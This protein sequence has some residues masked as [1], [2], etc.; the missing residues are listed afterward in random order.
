MKKLLADYPVTIETPVAWGEMDAFKHVNNI[1]YFRYFES[2][3]IAYF[4][5]L[6]LMRF[7]EET[8]IGPI[9]ASTQCK[10]KYPL[11]YPD[12]VTVG[13]TV[14]AIEEERFTM[15]YVVVSHTHEL[16]AAS[17]EGIIVSFNYRENKKTKIPDIIR[18]RIF[19]LENS[20][21]SP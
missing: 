3:R 1:V 9:L 4:E 14:S 12:T 21:P 20:A 13:A 16:I 15:N 11:T 10:Y 8:A 2:A 19:A 6:Q 7:M 5:K 18:E 17:G